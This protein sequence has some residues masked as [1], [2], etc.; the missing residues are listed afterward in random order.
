MD[1]FT[2]SEDYQCFENNCKNLDDI[3]LLNNYLVSMLTFGM[4]FLLY[5]YLIIEK[6]LKQCEEELLVFKSEIDEEDSQ[7][8]DE[9]HSEETEDDESN[10][11][12]SDSNDSSENNEDSSDLDNVSN[13]EVEESKTTRSGWFY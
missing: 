12:N 1:Q 10:S 13:K 11:D 9:E 2:C 4:G 8:S 3:I 5:N 7:E 6:K